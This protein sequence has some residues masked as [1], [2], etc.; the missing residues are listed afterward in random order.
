VTAE[1]R[2]TEGDGKGEE[3][4]TLEMEG[5]GEEMGGERRGCLIFICAPITKSWL[6][7]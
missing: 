5:K 2:D 6:R 7:L 3:R 4:G 1:G